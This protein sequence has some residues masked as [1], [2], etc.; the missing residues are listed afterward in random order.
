M[1][2]LHDRTRR[3]IGLAAFVLLGL[4]PSAA[5]TSW[6][7]WRHSSAYLRCQSE[8]LSWQLGLKVSLAGVRH[9]RPGNVL[10]ENVELAD[11]ETGR[12]IL[13][14]RLVETDYR[15]V[16]DA[17]G[18]PRSSLVLA[19]SQ[20]EI[21]AA[22]LGEVWRLVD[23]MLTR[24]A[25]CDEIELR[26]VAGEL[27]LKA[28]GASSTLRDVE[29]RVEILKAGT[30][31]ELVFGR[32]DDPAAG[33]AHIR[34]GRNCQ[35]TPP[36]TQLELDTGGG[37]LP[38][39]VLASQLGALG[40]L[41]AGSRFC[42]SLRVVETP[43]GLSG[44]L[45]GLLSDVNLDRLVSDRFPHKLSGTADVKIQNARFERGRLETAAGSLIAGP[46]VVSR[47]L[48]DSAVQCLG[49]T[50]EP[51]P[52]GE[53]LVPFHQI[54]MEFCLDERG[55]QLR[56]TCP[57][58]PS[59]TLFVDSQGRLLGEPAA[60]PMLATA[61]VRTLVPASEIQVPATRETAWIIH[62]LPM[63]GAVAAQGSPIEAHVHLH[64]VNQK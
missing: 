11:P 21:E 45:A 51:R 41:G 39:P 4:L 28:A 8:Q 63:P 54:A 22:E 60:Q 27:T 55:L 38:C 2:R 3:R 5:L 7:L 23:R 64:G 26:L 53:E 48:L 40:D 49:L 36:A 56:G 30:Q 44:E 19:A 52:P 59:G 58:R 34:V 1:F 18:T 50:G 14:C 37:P 43:D 9:V 13:H 24:R 57:A 10:Y 17:Q 46:G 62:R 35:I 61:L 12:V 42:G 33:P 29:G 20:P 6:G 32:A 15:R 31:A 25:G 16:T 47:S